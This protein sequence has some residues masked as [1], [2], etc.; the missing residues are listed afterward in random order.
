V[1]YII[2]LKTNSRFKIFK[3]KLPIY[4]YRALYLN[5]KF[6]SA[7]LNSKINTNVLLHIVKYSN[8]FINSDFEFVNNDWAYKQS[9]FINIVQYNDLM[10]GQWL[11]CFIHI[12]NL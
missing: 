8:T 7:A 10:G 1:S 5:S 9:C 12:L 11:V 3:Y 6:L 2:I 4:K